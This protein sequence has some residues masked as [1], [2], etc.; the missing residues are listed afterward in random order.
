[1]KINN[2][3]FGR[4]HS[5]SNMCGNIEGNPFKL[6]SLPNDA[7]YMQIIFCQSLYPF[8]CGLTLVSLQAICV[9]LK[10]KLMCKRK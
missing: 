9:Y 5:L 6:H 2:L 10:L 3:G 7:F 4:S 8:C 1:M